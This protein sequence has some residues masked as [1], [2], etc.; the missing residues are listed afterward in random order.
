MDGEM[1]ESY[2]RRLDKS[3]DKSGSI[4]FVQCFC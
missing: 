1:A 4:G 3:A 2:V